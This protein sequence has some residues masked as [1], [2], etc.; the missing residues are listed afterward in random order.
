M[1]GIAT[2]HGKPVWKQMLEKSITSPQALSRLFDLDEVHLQEVVSRYPTRI[3]PYYINLIKHKNDPIYRQCVPDTREVTDGY[4]LEDP[5]NEEELSPVPGLTHRYPDRVL[6]LVSARCAMYCRFCNRKRK[7]GHR[8]VVTDAS[9]REGIS[10]IRSN[11]HIRD[12][13][14]SGGDPLLLDNGK[15]HS[16]LSELRSISHVQILRIGTR[17]PCTLPQRITPQLANML[18]AFHP[19][20]IHTHFN[21]PDELTPEA[22][23]ACARLANAGIPLGCQTVLLKGVNDNPSTIK[24]LMQGLLCMRVRP[25]YLFQADL[26]KGTSHFWTPLDRGL[27]IMESLQGH[28]S[29]LCL[30]HFAVDLPGGGGKVLLT[31]ECIIKRDAQGLLVR[32]YQGE[33]QRYPGLVGPF[34]DKAVQFH[35]ARLCGRIR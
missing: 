21:H 7:V 2:K 33:E 22:S 8:S 18:K 31:P 30:P 3:N 4:G 11:N 5:L 27:A 26:A 14:L 17:V 34:D 1:T 10:Y 15:L 25:Y 24:A 9:V 19:L 12:V 16:I 23:L 29:G 35:Q 13:L 32:N 20:Y 6:F 28:T